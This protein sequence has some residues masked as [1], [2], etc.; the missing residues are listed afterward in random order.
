MSTNLKIILFILALTGSAY[1]L[2]KDN[3][4][5]VLSNPRKARTRKKKK[6]ASKKK[7]SKK[8]TPK[9]KTKK[10]RIYRNLNT[11]TLSAQEKTDKGWRVTMHPSRIK[12]KNAKF[13]VNQTGRKKVLKQKQKNVHAVIEGE[14]VDTKSTIDGQKIIYDPYKTSQFMLPSGKKVFEAE[15]VSVD[16][17]GN[18]RA[19][20]IV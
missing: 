8:K 9:K 10:V 16:A 3:A 5:P 18:I 15:L 12:L 4:A 20:G 14:L 11:G 13:K 19:K 7:S 6:K 1:F 2:S 17:K